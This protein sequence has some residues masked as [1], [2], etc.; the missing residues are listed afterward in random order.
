MQIDH[1]LP[2][3]CIIL[4]VNLH[5]KVPSAEKMSLNYP[6]FSYN[7]CSSTLILFILTVQILWSMLTGMSF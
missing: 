6:I 2:L 4:P 1:K 3:M 7:H 5:L